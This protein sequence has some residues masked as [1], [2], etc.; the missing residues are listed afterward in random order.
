MK[1]SRLQLESL[2]RQAPDPILIIST[3][4]QLIA[5]NAAALATYG[6]SEQE[7]VNKPI[8]DVIPAAWHKHTDEILR[9]SLQGDTVRNVES[10]R[11]GCHGV[12]DVLVTLI[13]LNDETDAPSGF[14]LFEKE[15][16]SLRRVQGKLQRL[17]RVFRDAAVPIIIE[18]MDG[19]ITDV[20]EAAIRKY[21]YSRVELIGASIKS[22]IPES[23]H[24]QSEGLLRR[25]VAGEEVRD[26]ETY[27]KLQSGESIP[28]LVTLSR[29]SDEP[30]GSVKIASFAKD[31]SGLK[32]A[33]EDLRML[34]SHL[35]QRV[36]RRTQQL[37]M[38]NER[39]EHE[40]AVAQEL[41]ES[42]NRQGNVYLL[43][44]SIAVRALHENIADA[45]HSDRPTLLIG[46]VGAGMESVAR[47]IH[48]LSPRSRGPFIY[49]N[50]EHLASAGEPLF[51]SFEGADSLVRSKAT[52]ARR[53]TLY[54]EAIE[55]L[56]F[57]AQHRLLRFLQEETEVRTIAYARVDLRDV[58]TRGGFDAELFRM[59]SER[60]VWIPPLED[61]K[62]DII[63]IADQIVRTYAKKL[64]KAITGLAPECHKRLEAY[65][66]PGNLD[67]LD[68]VLQRA[69]ILTH[70][71]MVDV[72]AELLVEGQ[73][74]GGYTMIR[75]LG[76][77]AMGEV[78]LGKHA[79]L[80][81]PAAIKIIRASAEQEQ[82][83]RETSEARFQ[84]EAKA[85]SRLRSPHTVELYDFGVTDQG[86]FYYVMEHLDGMDLELL[87]RREGPID[88]SRAVFLLDQLCL[89]LGEAHDLGIVHR[90]LKTQNIFICQLGLQ[91]DFLKVLDFGVVRS[92]MD[93]EV[94]MTLAGELAGSAVSMAPE[95]I[96]GEKPTPASD[97][98]SVGCLAFEMLTGQP[99]FRSETIISMLLQHAQGT[100]QLPSEINPEVPSELDELVL[101][102]L[103]KDPRGRIDSAQHLRH[104]LAAIPIH[105]PW[106]H[107]R[108]EVWW[109]EFGA[110]SRP[111]RS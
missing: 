105:R 75:P 18:D 86:Q 23:H 6:W 10:Q 40:L 42:S 20:N 62:Q 12:I 109:K 37:A 71:T 45:A 29:L 9:Q 49:I 68:N 48:N 31:I 25:C 102:C 52:L 50:C 7:C 66:W 51:E 70:G 26:V 94:S 58:T 33:E 24:A 34:N 1:L 89:S 92:V 85:T 60:R 32:R 53:G 104:Q 64:G 72:P 78:W 67:E 36:M 93:P 79:L 46:P 4:G 69:V 111:E 56:R 55:Q 96:A 91:F 74:I 107:E 59:L 108:A 65:S 35:E 110:K 15:A 77:G 41:T 5:A 39:L 8:K 57:P 21:G 19:I 22:I 88:P 90:D 11:V 99:V 87:L 76:H 43:G 97:I 82:K 84:R 95:L 30:G 17:A 83:D 54:L 13:Q 100:P 2:Y 81:R 98:Y 106:T 101:N 80:A 38:A 14:I 28:V 47:A 27:R 73:R 103:Q 44:D 61:R 63:T 16:S 3:S